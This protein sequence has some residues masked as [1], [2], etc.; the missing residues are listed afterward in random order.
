MSDTSSIGYSHFVDESGSSLSRSSNFSG[1]KNWA[2]THTKT[3][4]IVAAAII[5]IILIAV[6]VGVSLNS[7]SG[8]SSTALPIGNSTALPIGNTTIAGINCYTNTSGDPSK[9]ASVILLFHDINGVRPEMIWLTDAY[10]AAG[11]TVILPDLF[12]DNPSKNSVISQGIARKVLDAILSMGY[13]N[14]QTQG[15]CFGGKISV[16]LNQDGLIAGS[17][18]SHGSGIVDSDAQTL[19]KPIFFVMPE[20][21]PGFNVTKAALFQ[22]VLNSKQ[23][24]NR[25]IVYPKTTHGF[26]ANVFATDPY[27]KAEAMQALEDSIMWFNKFKA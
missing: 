21:D 4:V 6:I 27:L 3:I 19:K 17:V 14:I 16:V 22:A 1:W 8:S 9:I 13:Y 12:Q 5:S 20:S 24:S 7:N 23:I 26:A 10:A 18:S 11:Y 2:A 25:A 15:Y